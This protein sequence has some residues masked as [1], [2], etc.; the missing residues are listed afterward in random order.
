MGILLGIIP[1]I[2]KPFDKS[3]N[4]SFLVVSTSV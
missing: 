3:K 4:G 2:L 1:G